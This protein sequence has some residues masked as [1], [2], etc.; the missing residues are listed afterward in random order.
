MVADEQ[1]EKKIKAFTPHLNERQ[2]R[3]YLGHEALALGWGGIAKVSRLSGMNK[4]TI[5]AGI[6]EIKAGANPDTGKP[7][8]RAR[9]EGGGR[10]RAVEKHA[11]ALPAL[12]RLLNA[13]T[14]GDPM[15]PLLW[16]SKSLRKLER[17]LAQEGIRISYVTVGSILKENGF[18]LQ[19]NRK[20]DEGSSHIDRDAQFE[21]IN[22]TAASFMEAGQPVISVDCKKKELVGNYKNPGREWHEKG[23]APKVNVYD[24]PC[25]A[26]ETVDEQTGQAIKDMK[27]AVPYGVYDIGSNEGLVNVGINHDTAEFA[28]SSIY[29]W[30]NKMGR[31]RYTG[32]R[33]LLINA[34]GGGSN[35]SR[36]R[37]WKM[38]LQGLSN[39]TGLE[40]SVCHF[41]PGTSKW[42]KIEH[43]LF[44]Y[45]SINWRGKPLTSY[46]TVVELIANT[47][48]EAG[49]K[50][51]SVIDRKTYETGRKITDVEM[52]DI[53][54]VYHTEMPKWNYTI[55]P[56]KQ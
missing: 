16:S 52:K 11:E 32:A 17:E 55:K 36:S 54:I 14:R 25:K 4:E 23:A 43:R 49:L 15:K 5:R 46:Q 24:F 12:L 56:K 22:K 45:I 28:V 35:S 44:S 42:N 33:Q 6:K 9:K 27:K 8:N 3:L 18:S 34:D 21:H 13:H 38:E 41:P 51:E 29:T 48:T 2:T 7:P 20:T 1:L 40:I 39:K 10:K 30:W 37:L 31:E 47:K 19:A 50:V 53:N 26:Q